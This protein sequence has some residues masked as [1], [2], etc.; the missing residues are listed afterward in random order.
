[1]NLHQEVAL[2][3]KKVDD[4]WI[5]TKRETRF[6]P[7]ISV[8][9]GARGS[10]PPI[11]GISCCFMLREPVSQ[12]KYCCSLKVK[13][14]APPNFGLTK[15]LVPCAPWKPHYGWQRTLVAT[16]VCY[17][18]ARLLKLRRDS[19]TLAQLLCEETPTSQILFS[20]QLARASTAFIA[21]W[22]CR[23]EVLKTYRYIQS[24]SAR[25][26]CH[27]YVSWAVGVR[28]WCFLY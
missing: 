27:R 7:C 26:R 19:G 13:I 24:I 25:Q 21:K 15:L 20:L 8:T 23:K 12:T 14:F 11:S 10:C 3:F 4:P 5:R 28:L 17:P 9:R 1:M 16:F 22:K 2:S 6:V 18:D